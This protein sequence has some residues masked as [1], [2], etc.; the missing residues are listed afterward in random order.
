MWLYD[1]PIV[2]VV[3]ASHY[4]PRISRSHS[5]PASIAISPPKF[6]TRQNIYC[7]AVTARVSEDRPIY[8]PITTVVK[9]LLQFSPLLNTQKKH[10]TQTKRWRHSRKGWNPKG[11]RGDISREVVNHDEAITKQHCFTL[12]FFYRERTLRCLCPACQ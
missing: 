12:V 11:Y 10:A 7:Y 6:S 2:H 4:R 9:A 3:H 1:D 8:F 5:G